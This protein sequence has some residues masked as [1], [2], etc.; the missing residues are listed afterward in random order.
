[1]LEQSL[2]LMQLLRTKFCYRVHVQPLVLSTL[3]SLAGEDSDMAAVQMDD[4]L[5]GFLHRGQHL[6]CEHTVTHSQAV[7][8]NQGMPQ[9]S[10]SLTQ[11]LRLCPVKS[12][13]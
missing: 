10:I 13:C 12:Q 11:S 3:V 4:P 7:K 9:T 8:V 6:L 1:M 2:L 5:L